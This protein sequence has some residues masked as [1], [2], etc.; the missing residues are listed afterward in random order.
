MLSELDG[1]GCAV[2]VQWSSVVVQVWGQRRGTRSSQLHKDI[3]ALPGW[4][5]VVQMTAQRSC[6][7]SASEVKLPLSVDSRETILCIIPLPIATLTLM[8]KFRYL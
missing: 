5:G 3:C 4:S 7:E 8:T 1:A 6:T 2:S